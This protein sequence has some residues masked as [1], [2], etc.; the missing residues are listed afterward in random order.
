[1]VKSSF[2]THA[3]IF[4][5]LSLAVS[6]SP[7][8]CNVPAFRYALERWPADLYQV[9]VYH[10]A[11]PRGAEFALLAKSAAAQGGA[12]NYS[13]E[14]VDVGRPDG[15]ALADRRNITALPWVEVYYPASSEVTSPVWS[16]RLTSD[17]VSKIIESQARSQLVRR[18]L[19]GEVAV[20]VLVKS[21]HKANDRRALDSLTASLK[22]ASSTLRIPEIG[23]DLNGDPVAVTDF[24]SYPVRFSLVEIGRDDLGEELFVKALLASEPDLQRYDEPIAFPV[25][26]RGRALYALVGSGI[27]ETTILEACQSLVNWC[28]CEI[29][30]QNPGTDLLI[31]ADWSRPYRGKMVKDPELPLTGLSGFVPGQAVQATENPDAKVDIP[32][33]LATRHPPLAKPTPAACDVRPA[34]ATTV[35]ATEPADGSKTQRPLWRNVLYTAGGAGIVVV[36]LSVLVTLKRK[37]RL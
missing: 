5:L 20:W 7:E 1:L 24:K 36:A 30:A 13:L 35:A 17:A 9:V 2:R 4:G 15:K 33:P 32:S 19:D 16:G 28:S 12:A 18:L 23:T 34:A 8:A 37:N 14:L 6:G 26:G 27:Q 10:E 21:G 31:S 3:L 11:A 29:K 25:F 22:K